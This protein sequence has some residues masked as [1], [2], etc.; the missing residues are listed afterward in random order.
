MKKKLLILMLTV[1]LLLVGCT[2]IDKDGGVKQPYD[3]YDLIE[4]KKGYDLIEIEKGGIIYLESYYGLAPYY[5]SNGKLC[6]L[7]DGKITE[8]E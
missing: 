7:V 1:V 2:G 5:S 3:S 8:I 4:I 6:H